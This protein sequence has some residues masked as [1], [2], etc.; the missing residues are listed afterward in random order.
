M[1]RYCLI[2]M[3]FFFFSNS[4]AKQILVVVSPNIPDGYS[5]GEIDVIIDNVTA[6][7]AKTDKFETLNRSQ[8]SSVLSEEY[9]DQVGACPDGSCFAQIG[10]KL[11]ANYVLSFRIVSN[12]NEHSVEL[13]VVDVAV[14]KVVANTNASFRDSKNMFMIKDIPNEVKNLLKTGDFS[15]AIIVKKPHDVA[16]VVKEPVAIRVETKTTVNTSPKPSKTEQPPAAGPAKKISPVA[17]IIPVAV[18]VVGGGALIY[19]LLSRKKNE[20]TDD[21]MA[22]PSYPTRPSGSIVDIFTN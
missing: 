7:A 3:T 8:V 5:R 9:L 17:I 22:L 2:L 12:E 18:I 15:K 14:D 11:S 19:Y 10:A 16:P 6:E 1:G 4:S 13:T 20:T 21:I